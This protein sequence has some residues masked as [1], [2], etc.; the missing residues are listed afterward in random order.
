MEIDI[1]VADSPV[2]GGHCIA[3][4]YEMTYQLRSVRYISSRRLL[5]LSATSPLPSQ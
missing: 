2:T 4:G 1:I 3:T 5:L